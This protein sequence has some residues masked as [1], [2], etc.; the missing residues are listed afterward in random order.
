MPQLSNAHIIDT[1][2]QWLQLVRVPWLQQASYPE[3]NSTQQKG[4]IKRATL[5]KLEFL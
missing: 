4:L 1:A 3:L 2:S 5:L